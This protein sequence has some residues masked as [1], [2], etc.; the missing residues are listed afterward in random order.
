MKYKNFEKALKTKY[1][2]CKFYIHPND[3]EIEI[4]YS[5]KKYLNDDQFL[6]N[7]LEIAERYLTEDELWNIV[8]TY[9]L[10]NKIPKYELEISKE[11]LEIKQIM[12]NLNIEQLRARTK[13]SNT[14]FRELNRIPKVK[15]SNGLF[16]LI[17]KKILNI[18]EEILLPTL[19]TT[20]K[21][22]ITNLYSS[23][24]HNTI[25]IGNT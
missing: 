16:T 12:V 20:S 17:T 22:G 4:I 19:N 14:D 23:S 24:C 5:N 3:E 1:E 13:Y 8:T 6:D 2:D 11:Q 21:E 25:K 18:G 7:V 10:Y 15:R 9:D